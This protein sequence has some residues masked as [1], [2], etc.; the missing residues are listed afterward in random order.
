M[1]LLFVHTVEST[2]EGL[3][4]DEDQVDDLEDVED[5]NKVAALYTIMTKLEPC[6]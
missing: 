4:V 2:D 6:T 1:S 3:D 5:H